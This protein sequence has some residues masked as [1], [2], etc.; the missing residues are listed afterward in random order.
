MHDRKVD[1]TC[2]IVSCRV[3]RSCWL[4]TKIGVPDKPVAEAVVEYF[5]M[6]Q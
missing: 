4:R 3:V 5:D 1:Y 2:P 6:K